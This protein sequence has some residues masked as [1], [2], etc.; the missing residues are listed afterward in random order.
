MSEPGPQ[1]GRTGSILAALAERCRRRAPWVVAAALVAATVLGAWAGDRF[2]IDTDVTRLI[3]ADLPWRQ[4]EATLERLFPE[5][6]DLL[7]VVV[8]GPTPAIAEEGAELLAAAARARPELFLSV[9]RPD[10]GPFLTRHGLLYLPPAE[11]AAV[12]DRLIAAQPLLAT[13]A[14]DPTLR[15]VAEAITLVAEGLAADDGA[16]E[17]AGTTLDADAI[18][19]AFAALA[20][21]AEAARLGVRPIVDWSALLAAGD[22]AQVSR[23]RFVLIRPA[24]D[25]ARLSPGEVATQEIRRLARSLDLSPANGFRVRLTGPVALADEEFASIAEGAGWATV[26]SVALVLLILL[27]GLGSW[28]PIVAVLGTLLVGLVLTAAFGLAAVG[29]FNPI[30]IAFAALYIG[31]GVDFGIQIVVRYRAERRR[32][33]D[34]GEAGEAEAGDAAH[35]T[36]LGRT[37]RSIGG[38]VALAA[39]TTAIGFLAFL[40]TDYR[41]V[42]EL[43]LIA[44]A[45]ILIAALLSVTVLPAAL[46]L[47]AAPAQA[48][49]PRRRWSAALDRFV[50]QARPAIRIAALATGIAGAAALPFVAFDF[51]PLNLKDPGA[52]SAAMLRDL[53]RDPD[54]TPYTAEVL[55]P[56]E[57]APALAERLAALATVRRAVTLASFVPEEQAGKLE[58][59]ADAAFLLAPGLSPAEIAAAPAPGAAAAALAEAVHALTLLAATSTDTLGAAAGGLAAAIDGLE[60]EA[61]AAFAYAVTAGLPA[62]LSQLRTAL[63]PGPVALEGLPD[64]L[65]RAWRAPDGTTRIELYPEGDGRDPAVLDAFLAEIRTIEPA[66][67]GTVVGYLESART[68]A[69]SFAHAGIFALVAV[70]LVLALLLRR[71]REVALAVATLLLAGLWTAGLAVALGIDLTFANVI[72]LPLMLGIGVA[73][74]LYVLAAWRDGTRRLAEAPTARAVVLSALTTAAAFGSLALSPHRGTAGMGSLLL[75]SLATTVVAAL[76]VLPAFLAPPETEAKPEERP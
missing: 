14:A 41:G 48:A 42:A 67:T 75:L 43:G 26:A 7:V 33:A 6:A 68:V 30:S 3:A 74:A 69:R 65:R 1:S 19:E 28:R 8:D 53:A 54:T 56:A 32:V 29:R 23:R 13:L 44:G 16:A 61:L 51:D 21:S 52:E 36:A 34:E 63:S 71:A 70:T 20:Q 73:F 64:D 15:G 60:G 11:L 9:R 72:A 5:R 66:V 55:A 39:L 46:T 25:F 22:E 59:I 18:A 47:L 31:L 4:R 40:P 10:G 58:Q 27:F 45:G 17:S 38:T 35:A 76:V 49:R 37:V 57:D 50:Q 62:M 2:R 24:L 12:L